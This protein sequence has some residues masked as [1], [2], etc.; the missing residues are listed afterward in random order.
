MFD[1]FQLLV[2]SKI[3]SVKNKTVLI[4]GL[5][6][7]GGYSVET[8]VRSGISNLILVDNDKVDITN[9]NRQVVTNLNNIGEYK[10]KV[11]LDRI[12]SINPDCDVK[13][14]TSFITKD[15][16]DILFKY[17]IDYV[18]DAC[19]TVSTKIELIK[20]CHKRKIKLISSMGTGNKI[21][22][23]RLKII[24]IY[25]TSYDPLAKIIRK[26]CKELGI[27][28]QLVVCS[29]EQRRITNYDIIPSCSY[30]PSVAGILMTSYVIND[31]IGEKDV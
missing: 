22:P 23:S 30:V 17:N 14:I 21:D 10:T 13:I 27:K 1:R 7:V 31:I 6:G 4:I 16:I 19:D 11:W 25:K 8:L 2:G 5:G 15:N 26:K 24:D 3:D 9:L 28:K 20:E 29:D 18:I 12:K